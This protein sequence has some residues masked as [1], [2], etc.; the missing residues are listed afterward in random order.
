MQTTATALPAVLV[1]EPKV[2][3]DERGFFLESFNQQAFEQA[4][5]TTYTFVQDNH[6]LS[7]QGILRGLHYQLEQTQ[8]KLVRVVSGQVYDVAVD[9]RRSSPNFG[10]WAGVELSADNKRQIWVPPGFAHGFYVLSPQAEVLYKT[11]DYYHPASERTLAWDDPQVGIDWPLIG[12]P[13]LSAKDRQ[14]QTLATAEV[15]A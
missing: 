8:G 14:G 13:V 1:L 3:Q 4:T 12:D 5:Q 7:Q 15:F 2:F 11:T 6:S 10:Q 9:L